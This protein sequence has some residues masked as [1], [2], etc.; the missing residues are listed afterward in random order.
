MTELSSVFSLPTTGIAFRV[1]KDSLAAD[2]PY[3]AEAYD[4]DGRWVLSFR[5][6]RTWLAA[7]A[8]AIDG[9]PAAAEWLFRVWKDAVAPDVWPEVEALQVGFEEQAQPWSYLRLKGCLPDPPSK[10]TGYSFPI[11]TAHFKYTAELD[12]TETFPIYTGEGT[13]SD[14][15]VVRFCGLLHADCDD[16]PRPVFWDLG[17]TFVSAVSGEGRNRLAGT[18]KATGATITLRSNYPVAASLDVPG[19][20]R[21][22]LT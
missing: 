13:L 20:K 3:W 16:G 15:E 12:P 10:L 2:C 19:V 21:W 5:A 1:L 17:K 4:S 8:V 11:R 14:R 9:A 22:M 7:L 18:L 6:G